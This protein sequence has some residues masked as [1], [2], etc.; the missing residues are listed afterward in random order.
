MKKIIILAAVSLMVVS[1]S[2][3]QHA[4]QYS[5]FMF[6]KLN[7]NPAYAGSRDVLTGNALY[8]NQ[9]QAIDGAP[10]TLNF[11]V[12]LP[13]LQGRC[14][15]GLSVVSDQIG[16]LNTTS[17]TL[18]YNYSF[19]VG[20]KTRLGIGIMGRL[21]NGRVDWTQADPA[22]FND[23]LL[24]TMESNV[25]K[26]NFGAGIYLTNKKYYV[27]LSAPQLLRNTLYTGLEFVDDVRPYY[28]MAGFVM[29][30]TDN[31][32]LKPAALVSYNPS[33]PFEVDLNAMF[34]FMDAVWIG[35]TYRL[36]DSFD[37]VV[38]YQFTDQIRAGLAVDFTTSEL[39]N[40]TTGSYEVMVEYSFMYNDDGIKNLRYF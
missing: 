26:P 22:D 34:I 3:A 20:E 30:L 36:G 19:P 7:Y 9:W 12:H 25:T 37:A 16:M 4:P 11:N 23:S 13:F 18:S 24:G 39:M 17:A 29:N 31:I 35:G 33:S 6:N 28:L 40:Y 2:Y 15:A 27:G 8:R 14:G 32:K 1:S 38:Q 5:N 21:E 10:K